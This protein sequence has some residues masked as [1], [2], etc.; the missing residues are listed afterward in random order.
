ML[1]DKMPN[2]KVKSPMC[3]TTHPVVEEKNDNDIEVLTVGL[4]ALFK[5][6]VDLTAR[7][8]KLEGK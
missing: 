4:D 5:V 8:A 2:K 3:G 7:V 6:V 1:W